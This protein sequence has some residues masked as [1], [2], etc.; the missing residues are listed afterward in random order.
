M[1]TKISPSLVG[2]FVLG[3]FALALIALLSFG[4]VNFFS[5]PQRFIVYFNESI[6]GLDLGSP[7]KLRG[8]RVG[9]VV[10][11]NIRY[12]AA[13]NVNEVAVVCE[14]SRNMIA[15]SSGAMID[16]SDKAVLTDMVDHGLRAQLGVLGL[17]TGMLYVE[18]N[19]YDP[20]E[21][22][23]DARPVDPRG[24]YIPAVPSAISEYQASLSEILSDLKKVDFAGI[25][26]EAKALLVDLRRQVNRIETKELIAE[27]TKA[28][29]SVQRLS[30]SPELKTAIAGFGKASNDLSAVLNKLESRIEPTG[31]KLDEALAQAKT[32]I[33]SFNTTA[34]SLR[35]F[36]N[37][38][39]HLGDEAGQSLQKVGEAADAIQRLADFI[40]RN[41]AALIT[42]RKKPE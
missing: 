17:A 24:T 37:E 13:H 1:K 15:D 23:L 28:A 30:D 29:Q 35:R 41:P 32:A 25:S 33:D 16:V 4:G 19:F 11:L 2:F 34:L 3:A 21:Y 20:V 18:L 40:E 12:D 8:V 26:K 22:P 39:Q 9:R 10:D 36:V 38:N 14:L 31:Q 27:W 6:H 42:G 7:V 5:K